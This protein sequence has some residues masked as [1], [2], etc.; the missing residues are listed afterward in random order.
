[1]VLDGCR[2]SGHSLRVTGAQGLARLGVELW[3]IQL[4]GRWGT[5]TVRTYVRESQLDKAAD[6]A[7]MAARS[8]DLDALIAEVL[9][10]LEEQRQG[11][12][13]AATDPKIDLRMALPAQ[14]E[15]EQAHRE[16][17]LGPLEA[18]VT[19]AE[20]KASAAA[21]D[22]TGPEVVELRGLYNPAGRLAGTSQT[23]GVW[24]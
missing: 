14:P 3:V 6:R 8:R 9:R 24:H 18:E 15:V 23:R 22:G 12:G 4:L 13:A 21:R 7:A 19:I 17:A 11:T 2:G 20:E 16:D 5:D 1:M 10:K